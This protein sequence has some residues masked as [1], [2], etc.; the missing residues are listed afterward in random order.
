[1]P[2]TL[3]KG[4]ER[5]GTEAVQFSSQQMTIFDLEV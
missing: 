4:V 3:Y 5:L 1:M 2:K